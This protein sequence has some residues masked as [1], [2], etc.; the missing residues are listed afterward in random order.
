M[1]TTLPL[2][3]LLAIDFPY[4]AQHLKWFPSMGR[5]L[6]GG[7][8]E[9]IP[10]WL[11]LCPM[12][13]LV[14]C[15]S[16]QTRNLGVL[17]TSKHGQEWLYLL[18]FFFPSS[19]TFKPNGS[20]EQYWFH[21]SS[22]LTL[23]SPPSPSLV[24]KPHLLNLKWQ[25]LWVG[26][27]GAVIK[28]QILWIRRFRGFAGPKVTCPSPEILQS[29]YIAT[30]QLGLVAGVARTSRR[31]GLAWKLSSWVKNKETEA[32]I[33]IKKFVFTGKYWQYNKSG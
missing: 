7:H 1:V 23:P 15:L 24:R 33:K 20:T 9:K 32:E 2:D 14:Q 30:Q 8:N 31:V 19:L 22:G 17:E 16:C 29:L 18:F 3:I 13:A 11:R 6:F 4:S 10:S 28:H 27:Q 26:T 12:G 5:L 25:I 21:I